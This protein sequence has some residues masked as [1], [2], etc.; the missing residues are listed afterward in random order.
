MKTELVDEFHPA[1]E[2]S[3][4]QCTGGGCL[5]G[6]ESDG[7]GGLGLAIRGLGGGTDY[8]AFATSPLE[9]IWRGMDMLAL[10]LED[11]TVIRADAEGDCCSTS[12]IEHLTGSQIRGQMVATEE[13]PELASHD[14]GH[15]PDDYEVLALY[16]T[17]FHFADGQTMDL[18]YR[19]DSNGYYGGWINYAKVDF[20]PSEDAAAW[21]RVTE[22]F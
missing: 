17:R 16:G 12:W 15:N 3:A 22:D 18:D 1:L 9:S 4:C 21:R 19:N 7:W 11:G 8:S 20:K 5:C 10:V 2:C 13:V 14:D 6:A